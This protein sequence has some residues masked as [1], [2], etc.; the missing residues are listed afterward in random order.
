MQYG[1]ENKDIACFF[2][3]IL[4]NE[5]ISQIDCVKQLE[6]VADEKCLLY[7]LVSDG[8]GLNNLGTVIIKD[9]LKKIKEI[10]WL[11][12]S[13]VYEKHTICIKYI[14]IILYYY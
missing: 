5:S 13:F 4:F 8:C 2:E 11:M 10:L 9:E 1:K 14:M 3:E 7:L 12:N 6:K